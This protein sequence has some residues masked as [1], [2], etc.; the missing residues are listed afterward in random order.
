MHKLETVNAANCSAQP[1]LLRVRLAHLVLRARSSG[2]D[3]R[4]I[5]VSNLHD[6]FQ[7]TL[8]FS[9]L[10]DELGLA[11]TSALRIRWCSAAARIAAI[12]IE[13]SAPFICCSAAR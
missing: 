11:V 9:C 4:S 12:A 10:V 7:A 6:Y 5:L 8:C 13:L 1:I 2:S 3:T